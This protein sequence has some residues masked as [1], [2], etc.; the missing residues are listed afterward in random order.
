MD[1]GAAPF[2][3]GCGR[4]GAGEGDEACGGDVFACVDDYAAFFS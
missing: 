2:F 4:D 3:Y 1:G